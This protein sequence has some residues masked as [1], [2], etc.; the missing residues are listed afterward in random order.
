MSVFI[1]QGECRPS[2]LK[3]VEISLLNAASFLP[4]GNTPFL[5]SVADVSSCQGER[6]NYVSHSAGLGITE[7]SPDEYLAQATIFA[8]VFTIF[9]FKGACHNAP[10]SKLA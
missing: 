7:G 3:D 5:S 6:V 10:G 1:F 2:E 9:S 4:Q 8:S